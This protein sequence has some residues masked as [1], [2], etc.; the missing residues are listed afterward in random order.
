MKKRRLFPF[1]LRRVLLWIGF[2]GLIA[3]G[4]A[5]LIVFT[6]SNLVDNTTNLDGQVLLSTSQQRYELG[7]DVLFTVLNDSGSRIQITNSCPEE[8]LLVYRWQDPDW[9][10]V[11]HYAPIE[12]CGNQDRQIVIEPHQSITGSYKNW[13]DLFEPGIYRIAVVVNGYGGL[14]YQDIEVLNP[15]TDASEGQTPVLQQG[16]LPI[17]TETEDDEEHEVEHE[18]EH[19]TEL[20]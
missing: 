5:L 19:E 12:S 13:S 17:R 7:Q 18:F 15:S 1:K 20:D 6:R 10:R 2:Y 3:V 9:K 14:A 4:L 8:P 11:H 16:S